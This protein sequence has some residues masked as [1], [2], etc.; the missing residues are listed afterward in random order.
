MQR[1]GVATAVILGLLAGCA[2]PAPHALGTTEAQPLVV[3][4][5][6]ASGEV[7][8]GGGR[9]AGEPIRLQLAGS[10]V[11]ASYRTEWSLQAGSCLRVVPRVGEPVIVSGAPILAA[12]YH[13]GHM[14]GVSV[15]PAGPSQH[16]RSYFEP[17]S[18][19]TV[20]CPP[21]TAEPAH[22]PPL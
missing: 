20:A 6:N 11:D 2:Q 16:L 10:V 8:L 14:L 5:G 12:Y 22:A 17:I 7:H 21:T 15:G 3:S 9:S 18:W 19:E 4:L 1:I 13:F